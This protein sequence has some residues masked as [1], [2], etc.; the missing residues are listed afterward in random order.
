LFGGFCVGVAIVRQWNAVRDI[1]FEKLLF[2]EIVEF[3]TIAR[4]LLPSR[5]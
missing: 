4:R 2:G 5:R 1:E 3:M